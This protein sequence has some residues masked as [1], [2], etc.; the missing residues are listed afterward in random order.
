MRPGTR[1]VGAA[2]MASG[3]YA[4][5]AASS[6]GFYLAARLDQEGHL[7]EALPLYAAR[8]AETLTQ[9]D[10]LRWAGALLRAGEGERARSVF[11]QLAD[12][13][14]PVEH[15]GETRAHAAAMCASTAIAAGYPEVA[16]PY[17]RRALASA[18]R[19]PAKALLLARAL[20]AAG[21]VTAARALVRDVAR[22]ADGW[23]GTRRV[24][25]ARWH[26]AT[27]DG[28][29][30]RVLLGRPIQESLGQLFQDSVRADLLLRRREWA[31]AD[32]LLAASERKAPSGLLDETTVDRAWRNVERELRWVKLRRGLAL[33][34]DGKRT[35]AVAAARKAAAA[36]EEYVRAAATVLLAA[37]ALAEGQRDD[38]LARLVVVAGH[39]RRFVAAAS[40]EPDGLAALEAALDATDRSAGFLTRPLC[41]AL[42]SQVPARER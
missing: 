36:D 4:P 32:A 29:A 27:G 19:D 23:S 24:E 5:P 18:P 9:S 34:E 1:L 42:A 28:G 25:L 11:D 14:G 41:A 13:I 40:L 20:A 7:A 22:V 6:L 33:W 2:V 16:V 26:L 30:A 10:R 21:D 12:E 38:A 17:A 39:N 31:Q 35:A 8:A 3:V 37:A 15:G